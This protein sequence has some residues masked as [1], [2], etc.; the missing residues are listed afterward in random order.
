MTEHELQLTVRL[1]FAIVER[2]KVTGFIHAKDLAQLRTVTAKAGEDD[3][4]VTDLV[5]APK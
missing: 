5:P 3:I 2:A 4:D 1:L